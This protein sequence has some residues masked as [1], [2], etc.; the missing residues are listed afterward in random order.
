MCKTKGDVTLANISREISISTILCSIQNK[1]SSRFLAPGY[2][3]SMF[4]NLGH[5]SASYSY[6]KGS[7]KKEY[8]C[9][10]QFM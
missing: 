6:C 1:S 2:V 3:L 10:Y 7:C 8:S 5:F 4:L 9:F